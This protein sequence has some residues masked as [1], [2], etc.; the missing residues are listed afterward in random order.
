MADNV[1]NFTVNSLQQFY[2]KLNTEILP[3]Y[4]AMSYVQ[5]AY[6]YIINEIV[7]NEYVIAQTFNSHNDR[8]T[9]LETAGYITSETQPDW[10][11]TS[12]SS[13]AYIK[14]KPTITTIEVDNVIDET[15][16]NAASSYA[17]AK[18]LNDTEYAVGM[19][20][21][22]LNSRIVNA[23]DSIDGIND[24][25]VSQ[26][27]LNTR[28]Q[29][30]GYLTSETQP[31][32]NVTNTSSAA[33]IKN[34]PTIPSIAGLAT[35]SY[36]NT[37]VAGIVNS[38]PET[39]DTL[40]ELAAAL[41]NDPDFATTTATEIGT[42]VSK[43]ELAGLGYVTQTTLSAQGYLTSFTESDPTVPSHVKSITQAN[44]NAW[45]SYANVQ[46][47]WNATSGDAYIKNKPTIPSIAG[48]VS[49][50]T[51]S[52][53]SYVTT[54][55]L[56]TRLNNAGYIS[57]IP[58]EYITQNEL[59]A[60]GYLTSETKANWNETNSNS[61]AY[62]QNK[63]TIPAAANDATITIAKGSYTGTFTTNAS[64]AKTINL[65]N[66]L[67]S[68]SS[69]DSGKILSVNSSG[70]LVWITPVSIYTGSGEPANSLGNDGDI[71]LQS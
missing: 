57:S 27:T 65:P 16:Y 15:S 13:A 36:V 18:A 17:V 20:L 56:N 5:S 34:K 9:T 44:I 40:N 69:S 1:R 51:L 39:L 21:N 24:N 68:Y 67:P 33:Y 37:K 32:W 55:A 64:T 53:Q 59:S 26:Y 14:N 22:D 43:T 60:N 42:K 38:A 58:S 11:V 50:T 12:T 41:G 35:E 63:P 19:A 8:L 49:Q 61:A 46:A 52:N 3:S 29:N 4:A 7:D 45:N 28:L 47:D 31:D 30:A 48:L 23:E 62:I 54:T 10:N 25:Y 71:Y 66:E 6:S 2:N 70:Q